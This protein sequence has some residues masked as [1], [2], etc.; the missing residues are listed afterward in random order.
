MQE[1]GERSGA[2]DNPHKYLLYKPTFGQLNTFLAS[3]FKELPPNGAMLLYI[4]ADG[5]HGN[6]KHTDDGK[7]RCICMFWHFCMCV[8]THKCDDTKIFLFV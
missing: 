1:N 6:Q 2:R 8:L 4:S 5:S 3:A 7:S